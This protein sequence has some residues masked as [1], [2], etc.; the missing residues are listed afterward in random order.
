[1]KSVQIRGFFVPYSVRIQENVDQKKL[2]I[3]T[4]FTWCMEPKN[5]QKFLHF[6]DTFMIDKYLQ[7][8]TINLLQ[9]Y[10]T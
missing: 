5:V 8:L 1:M 6:H 2:R 9:L 7:S 10:E 4:I 3:W